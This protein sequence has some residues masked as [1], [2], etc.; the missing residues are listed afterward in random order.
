MRE[1]QLF[2]K[3]PNQR[4]RCNTCQWRCSIIPGNFGVYRMY[5]NRDGTL[6]LSSQSLKTY[7][8]DRD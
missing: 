4:V 1:A 6:F 7:Y 5:Q 8:L 3:F 2:E